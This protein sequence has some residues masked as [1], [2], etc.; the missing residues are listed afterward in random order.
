[1]ALLNT[2]EKE[3]REKVGIFPNFT[4]IVYT[5]YRSRDGTHPHKR[6]KFSCTIFITYVLCTSMLFCLVFPTVWCNIYLCSAFTSI[7]FTEHRPKFP[8]HSPVSF[9][10]FLLHD[11]AS[12]PI[13]QCDVS[14][15]LLV[16]SND[17][18]SIRCNYFRLCN[19]RVNINTN[20]N[21]SRNYYNFGRV[22]ENF[23]DFFPVLLILFS[24]LIHF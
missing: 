3:E 17:F 9:V 18:T 13:S 16:D 2:T 1:M 20:T 19:H 10:F 11:S 14:A 4:S 15:L 22:E 5:S 24:L 6:E 7:D 23:Q 8:T 21:L 12:N